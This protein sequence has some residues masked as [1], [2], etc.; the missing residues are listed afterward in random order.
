MLFLKLYG[1]NCQYRQSNGTLTARQL[2]ATE[3]IAQAAEEK[4]KAESRAEDRKRIYN[5]YRMKITGCVTK[6]K[7]FRNIRRKH[8]GR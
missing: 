4:A 3:I 5:V 2:P 8:T 1:E 6:S 7:F